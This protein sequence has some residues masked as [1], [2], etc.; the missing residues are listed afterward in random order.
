MDSKNNLDPKVVEDFGKEWQTFNQEYLKG[1]DLERAFDEYFHLFPFHTLASDC[2]GFDMGC[3]SGRWARLV[4]PRVGHLHCIDPSPLALAQAQKNLED[5]DNLS[6][7][8]ASV[9][10]STLTNGSQDFGYCLGVLHHIP[11]T[12]AGLRVCA[13][14]LKK[15]SPFLL[16]LYY[17]FD[18]KPFWF[19]M[20]W[21]V[22]DLARSV[23]SRLPFPL[24]RLICDLIALTVY[25][26]M[27]RIADGLEKMGVK[28]DNIP[29]SAYRDKPY[30]F[31]RT[32]ALD[33][34]GTRLEKRFTK[35]EIQTMME[36]SGFERIVFSTRT[37]HWVCLGY[38]I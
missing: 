13:E 16:Y 30:P 11:D 1:K 31:L 19:K 17:R 18:Q 5:C 27:A 22:S 24:K 32:D 20:I 29:L 35:A 15:G 12:E 9:D 38:K 6:F 37:P 34:F 28:V 26:P 8:V 14:K 25:L 10:Q 23:L 4:S 33:R 7:E 21:K 2:K 3:G 36:R